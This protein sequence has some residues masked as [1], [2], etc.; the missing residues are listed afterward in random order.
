MSNGLSIS[1]HVS[2]SEDILFGGLTPKQLT[3]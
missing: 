2:G 1:V 3:P